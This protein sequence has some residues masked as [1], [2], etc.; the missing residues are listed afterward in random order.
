MTEGV[1]DHAALEELV[2]SADPFINP[3]GP[4]TEV[5]LDRLEERHDALHQMLDSLLSVEPQTGLDLAASLWRFWWMRGHMTEGREMLERACQVDG[6]KLGFALMGLG[7][8]AF[9]QGD[10][11]A[12]ARV[13]ERR[14]DLV[15]SSGN[16][17]AIAEA[18]GD[19]A[20][21]A[22]RRGDFAAVRNLAELGYAAA[23]NTSEA[24]VRVPLHLRAAAARMEGRFDEA[25]A[26]YLESRNLNERLGNFAMVAAEDHNL[27]YV[28]LHS[29]DVAEAER[30]FNSSSEW[31]FAHDNAYLRPYALLDAGVL[32]MHDGSLD[33][34]ARLVAAAQRI[35]ED[36]DSIPDPDDA[37]EL[38]DAVAQLKSELGEQFEQAWTEGRQLTV[39]E[40]Q[41]FA[42]QTA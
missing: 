14:L 18:Y 41:M 30:R 3:I 35:F 22:L 36:T 21:I 23:A 25:R 12:A 8:I 40:A 32:A 2:R 29:G 15:K 28:E 24:A 31:I 27:V 5:W 4:E 17:D 38:R 26:L 34:A 10:L 13:F 19:M 20:R 6:P 39:S 37:V 7:T 42:L 11:E 9:R 33:R 16:P 1:L